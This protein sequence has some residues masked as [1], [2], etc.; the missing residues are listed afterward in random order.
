MG[1]ELAAKTTSGQQH[2]AAVPIARSSLQHQGQEAADP[3][4][5]KVAGPAIVNRQHA[6]SSASQSTSAGPE[7]ETP[8]T[9]LSCCKEDD[10]YMMRDK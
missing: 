1:R 8:E 7:T 2:L 6:Y 3:V 4:P 9:K 5:P 10:R